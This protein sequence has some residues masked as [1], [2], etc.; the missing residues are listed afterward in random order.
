MKNALILTLA[1]GSTLWAQEDQGKKL[2]ENPLKKNL[3]ASPEKF[4]LSK[5]GI[6]WKKG[7]EAAINREK[8]ILL[9]QLLGNYDD[10]YC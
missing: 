10:V 1:L 8:P 7:L 4:D 2:V 5:T 3:G 6:D 9:F